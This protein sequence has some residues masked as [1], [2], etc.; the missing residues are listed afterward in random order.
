[1]ISENQAGDSRGGEES[2]RSITGQSRHS[3]RHRTSHYKRRADLLGF[4]LGVS[5]FALFVVSLTLSV[6]VAK[7]ANSKHLLQEGLVKSGAEL[8]QMQ[9]RM[10]EAEQELKAVVEGRFPNLM[11]LEP[12]KVFDVKQYYAKNI[13]FTVINNGNHKVYEYKLVMENSFDY[14]VYPN[15]R[16]LVFDKTGIQAGMDD[17]NDEQE[18]AP[19]ESRSYSQSIDVFLNSDPSYFTLDFRTT[20]NKKKQIVRG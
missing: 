6:Q 3:R 18:L 2:N 19:G 10:T 4:L 9:T 16:L 20:N 17:I 8:E 1:M 14:P 5:V 12:D 13:V 7:L 11:P 15:V